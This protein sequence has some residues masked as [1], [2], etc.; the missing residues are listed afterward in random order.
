[1]P[2]YTARHRRHD[3][4]GRRFSS[5][6]INNFFTSFSFFDSAAHDF[7]AALVVIN[8]LMSGQIWSGGD[9]VCRS[10]CHSLLPDVFPPTTAHRLVRLAGL[11]VFHFKH[12]TVAVTFAKWSGGRLPVT[13]N[14]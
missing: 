14:Q 10:L 3:C 7:N 9:D 12:W 6:F 5:G 8:A 13:R 11:T 4:C 2:I 1:M